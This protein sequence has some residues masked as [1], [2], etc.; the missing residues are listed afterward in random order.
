MQAVGFPYAPV[1]LPSYLLNICSILGIVVCREEENH[2]HH[3][4]GH[5]DK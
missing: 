4:L 3:L 5:R 2:V 1:S